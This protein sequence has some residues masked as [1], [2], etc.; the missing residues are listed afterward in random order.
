[1]FREFEP[2]GQYWCGSWLANANDYQGGNA[3]DIGEGLSSKLVLMLVFG[4]GG[5]TPVAE[6]R[7]MNQD[8]KG[9][10]L[11]T[12]YTVKRKEAYRNPSAIPAHLFHSLYYCQ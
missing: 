12:G 6:T 5:V 2:E 10:E 3:G 8:C 4:V 9:E 11:I 1:V 7:P